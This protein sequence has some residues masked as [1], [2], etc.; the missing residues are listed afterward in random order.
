MATPRIF[1]FWQAPRIFDFFNDVFIKR[2]SIK[3]CLCN[4]GHK[5]LRLFNALPKFEF[6]TSETKCFY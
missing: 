1:R 2:F 3:F 6:N 5:I 4:H